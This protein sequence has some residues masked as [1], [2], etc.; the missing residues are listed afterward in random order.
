M[1]TFS[2]NHN[3]NFTHSF[4]RLA[5]LVMLVALMLVL[6]HASAATSLAAPAQP[7]HPTIAGQESL[8][9]ADFGLKLTKKHTVL[10]NWNTGT[11]M[12]ILGFNLWKQVGKGEW[13]LM[14]AEMIAAKNPGELIGNAYAFTDKKVTVGKKYSYKLEVVSVEGYSA[15][16]D[17]I[18]VKVK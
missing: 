5:A 2:L 12:Q 14:N 11:E 10:L 4:A 1:F 6:A 16:T 15:F 3:T 13:K 9:L 7:A 17:P 8:G 18:Q